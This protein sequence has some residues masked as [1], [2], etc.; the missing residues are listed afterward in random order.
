MEGKARERGSWKSDPTPPLFIIKAGLEI[1]CPN[2]HSLTP[3]YGGLN[4]G[5]GRKLRRLPAPL[6]GR[7]KNG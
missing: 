6:K 2:C 4:R 7:E 5:K 1:L 3:T